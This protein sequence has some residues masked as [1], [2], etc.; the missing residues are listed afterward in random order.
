MRVVALLL[1]AL[2]VGSGCGSRVAPET[3][4]SHVTTR[5][6]HRRSV[7]WQALDRTFDQIA[8]QTATAERIA[9]RHHTVSQRMAIYLATEHDIWTALRSP[10]FAAY[11]D[12][13][14]QKGDLT[15]DRACTADVRRRYHVTY[16][17]EEA[18]RD[19]GDAK[20]WPDGT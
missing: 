13:M 16:A 20:N 15:W 3:V 12:R 4:A 7:N 17:D 14:I 2:F 9:A 5:A 6:P 1:F 8:R 19:E 11:Q 18:I 10:S